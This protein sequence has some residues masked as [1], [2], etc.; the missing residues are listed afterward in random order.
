M[1]VSTPMNPAACFYLETDGQ[2]MTLEFWDGHNE[3]DFEKYPQ[4]IRTIAWQAPPING[5]MEAIKQSNDDFIWVAGCLAAFHK[6]P[7]IRNDGMT[8]P[9]D[10][11]NIVDLTKV[12][13]VTDDGPNEAR[14]YENKGEWI[15]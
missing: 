13:P 6:V 3:P 12:T 7:L 15:G 11:P 9:E 14:Y 1:T 4:N 5:S 2:T 10:E 8:E